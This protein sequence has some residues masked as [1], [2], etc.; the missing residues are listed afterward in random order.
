MHTSSLRYGP[1]LGAGNDRALPS[2]EVRVRYF[3]PRTGEPCERK[4]RPLGRDRAA[5]RIAA[6]DAWAERD[7]AYRS[8]VDEAARVQAEAAARRSSQRRGGR[9]PRP[10]VVDGVAHPSV[11]AAARAI[12]CAPS[13]LSR[14]L[15][16]GA[17]EHMGHSVRYEEDR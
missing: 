13:H 5:E 6:R 1:I 12:G 15:N 3:D 16:E 14:K 11:N 8:A 7:R 17:V 2:S 9:R 4:P 10:V